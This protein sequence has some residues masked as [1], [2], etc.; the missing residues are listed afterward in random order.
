MKTIEELKDQLAL[1]EK[2]LELA[3]NDLYWICA[4]SGEFTKEDFISRKIDYYT[5]EAKETM[6]SE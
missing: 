5:K 6:R 4:F 2:A 3:C 1:T